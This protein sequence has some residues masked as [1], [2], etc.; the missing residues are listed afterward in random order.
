MAI[1]ND[2]QQYDVRG[3]AGSTYTSGIFAND[4]TLTLSSASPIIP[5]AALDPDINIPLIEPY[6]LVK[7]LIKA[8]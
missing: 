3:E 2:T 6:F 1:S 7:Y 5:V 8:Y 4:L